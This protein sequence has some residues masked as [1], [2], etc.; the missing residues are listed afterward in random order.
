MPAIK[1]ADKGKSM[2]APSSAKVQTQEQKDENVASFAAKLEA[3]EVASK[4]RMDAYTA[5]MATKR[6]AFEA[7]GK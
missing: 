6:A 3:A 4:E 7:K 2:R 1:R 5:N